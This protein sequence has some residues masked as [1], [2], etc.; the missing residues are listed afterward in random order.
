MA[1]EW[2]IPGFFSRVIRAPQSEVGRPLRRAM[3]GCMAGLLLGVPA[4]VL[5]QPMVRLLP[6]TGGGVGAGP[7]WSVTPGVPVTQNLTMQCVAVPGHAASAGKGNGPGPAFTSCVGDMIFT[8][9]TDWRLQFAGAQVGGQTCNV[10]PYYVACPVNMPVGQVQSFAISFDPSPYL[11]NGTQVFVDGSG[12]F[13]MVPFTVPIQVQ[14]RAELSV[15]QDAAA[16]MPGV[17]GTGLTQLRVSNLGPSG[18][19]DVKVVETLGR[20]L[21]ASAL[22]GRCQFSDTDSTLVCTWPNIDPGATVSLPLVIEAANG[23]PTSKIG[24][25]LQASGDIGGVATA[26]APILVTGKPVVGL[27]GIDKPGAL[28]VYTTVVDQVSIRTVSTM[29]GK[30]PPPGI[31]VSWTM[32][33]PAG[34]QVLAVS[35]KDDSSQ[36]VCSYSAASVKCSAP[37]FGSG[38]FGSNANAR[39]TLSLQQVGR[40]P[41]TLSWQ[42]SQGSG[43][44]V[45]TVNVVRN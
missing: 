32:T 36:M 39:I 4:L 16:V 42:S 30:I 10:Q 45:E 31:P 7:S 44:T 1:C 2:R 14:P 20:W 8:L 15:S 34:V 17:K 26:E 6:Q 23:Y 22:G 37:S 5:A 29:L 40:Q 18:I 19:S 24:A 33:V 27:Q 43:T 41:L 3:R 11:R 25:K 28:T 12:N 13:R 38:Q 9:L 35:V 21:S